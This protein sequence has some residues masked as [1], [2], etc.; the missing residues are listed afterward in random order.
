VSNYHSKLTRRGGR[1]ERDVRR[2][3]GEGVPS[4]LTRRGRAERDVRREG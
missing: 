3:G 4:K 2:R 1:A